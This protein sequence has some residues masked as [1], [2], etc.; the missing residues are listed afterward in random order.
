MDTKDKEKGDKSG[1]GL[2]VYVVLQKSRQGDII[3]KYIT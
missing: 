1:E 2:D 3:F